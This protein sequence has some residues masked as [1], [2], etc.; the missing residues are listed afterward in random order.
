MKFLITAVLSL[1]LIT[2]GFSQSGCSKYYP[3]EEGTTLQYTNYDKKG[4][5]SG[6]LDYKVSNVRNNG[7]NTTA[8]FEISMKDKK[9]E[10]IMDSS[11]DISCNGNGVV[12]DYKSMSNAQ[13][14]KQFENF[15]YEISGTDLDLPNNLSVGQKLKDGNMNMKISMGITMEMKIT[16]KNREIIGKETIT[17]PAGSFKCYILQATTEIDM[18]G[19]NMT[20]TSKSW[21]SEGVGMVKQE[22]KGMGGKMDSSSKLTKLVL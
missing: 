12:I 16:I 18:M 13:M 21:F 8:T 7:G 22:T 6:F 14:M 17:T 20:S 2:T 19:R 11:Y 3:F 10:H 5:K 9:G 1:F 4:K 15:E